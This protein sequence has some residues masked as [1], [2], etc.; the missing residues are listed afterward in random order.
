MELPQALKDLGLVSSEI[1]VYLYLL[2]HGLSTPTQ[3]A[4]GTG[5]Q[6]TNCYHVLRSLLEKGLILEQS[7]GARSAYLTNDPDALLLSLERKREIVSQ[8]LPDLRGLQNIQRNKPTIRFFDGIS[9]IEQLYTLALETDELFGLGSTERIYKLMPTFFA[10]WVKE[11]KKRN[12]VIHDIVTFPS[13]KEAKQNMSGILKGLYGAKTLPPTY[14]ELPTDL[15][16]WHDHVALITLE[17]PY[18]GTLLTNP[19]L[20]RTFK[21]VLELLGQRL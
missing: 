3:I 21:I 5:I 12:I 16:V 14:G 13:S 17:E 8:I 20:A 6:R 2:E 1:R 18:F 4:R 9:Q 10:W 7:K 11:A 19:Q 15:L